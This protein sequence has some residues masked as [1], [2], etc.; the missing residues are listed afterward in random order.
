LIDNGLLVDISTTD[1]E[2]R[3]DAREI[4][5]VEGQGGT[6]VVAEAGGG[7]EWRT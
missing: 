6:I 3:G 2:E 7:G 5:V 4:A 1:A